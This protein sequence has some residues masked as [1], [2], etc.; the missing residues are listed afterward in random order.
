MTIADLYNWAKLHNV[1][2]ET[3]Y[4]DYICDDDVSCDYT[5]ELKEDNLQI[6]S[7]NR[8]IIEIIN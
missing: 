3:L 7:T 6:D 5:G 1:E 2:N 8:P 4:I